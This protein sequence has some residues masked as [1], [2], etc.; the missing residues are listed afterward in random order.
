MNHG[1]DGR[2]LARAATK[3]VGR[4]HAPIV[5]GV[6]AGGSRRRSVAGDSVPRRRDVA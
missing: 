3:T 2:F 4:T 6:L 1:R 5:V